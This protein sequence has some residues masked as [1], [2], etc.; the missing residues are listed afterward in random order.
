MTS[1]VSFGR[2]VRHRRKAL[3]LTQKDLAQRVGCSV[4]AIRKLEADERRPSQ[5][6]A[7]RLAEFLIIP[8]D[9]RAAF[10]QA[11]RGERCVDRLSF[12]PPTV[13][14]MLG[15]ISSQRVYNLPVPLTPLLGRQHELVQI[16]RL[17]QDPQCRLLTLTG[18]GGIGK[19]RLAIEVAYAQHSSFSD[20]VYFV[21][22][23]HVTAIE[24][25]APTIADILGF[26]FHGPSD[27]HKQLF[28]YLHEKS[29]LLV[30]DNFEHLLV[31]GQLL[32]DLLQN[33]PG[34][35]VLVTS[36]GRLNVHGEWVFEVQGLPVPPLDQH[37]EL[38]TY[39]A[40]ALF[41]QSARRV[42]P[43]FSLAECNQADVARICQL[44]D[45][46]PLG[47]ELAATWIRVL[48]CSEIAHEIEHNVDFLAVSA[49][50]IPERHRS[51]RAA[52]DHSWNLLSAE[53][54]RVMRQLAVF[55]GGFRREAAGQVA[56][57]S[58]PLLSALVDKSLL[59]RTGVGRYGMHQLVEQYVLAH[60]EADPGECAATHDRYS[61]YYA[62]MLQ[63]HEE[64]LKA[65]IRTD[66]VA[67]LTLEIDNLRSAW[68][69][70]VAHQKIVDIRQAVRS[71]FW[72]YESR[73]WLREGESVFR[74][75]AD[76]LR[77]AI[78]PN[79]EGAAEY[80]IALG[81]ALTYQAVFHYRCGQYGWAKEL[82]EQSLE[83]L[84]QGN[85]QLAL[86]EAL[87]HL[88]YV[89]YGAGAYVQA[90]QAIDESLSISVAIR[91]EWGVAVCLT[92]L[93]SITH[94]RGEYQE[95]SDWFRQGLMVWRKVGAARGTAYCLVL[96]GSTSCALGQYDQAQGLLRES[97]SISRALDDRWGIA[98]TLN[99]LGM[100]FHM[101]GDYVEAQS[102]FRESLT[103]F[104]ELGDRL[105]IAQTLNWLGEV[106]RALGTQPEAWTSFLE[107]IN[108]ATRM[109]T[110][111]VVLEALVGLASLSAQEGSPEWA[112]ELLESVL[113]HPAANK[114][115]RDRA[116]QLHTRLAVQ[117][118]P[119][120]LE[121]IHARAQ[122]K[123]FD[124]FLE[125][126]LCEGADR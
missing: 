62:T 74:Q 46:M 36:R 71:L 11:A 33:A 50:G 83:L 79:G 7:E 114:E 99:A 73:G 24:Y 112:L 17:L 23:A 108:I 123:P 84:R 16:N 121:A 54:Q 118:P 44:L 38:E 10:V 42:A 106:H 12:P 32:S 49:R 4:S 37:D 109:D 15:P 64:A 97:L 75:A 20:G 61:T 19:T 85:D 55:R 94:A 96:F 26:T 48:S 88:A 13:D 100:L 98:S 82:L 45:G 41:L 9:D 89:H 107:A 34:A 5:Q 6:M 25:V 18:L 90:H 2:W 115:V 70:A 1:E 116:Q 51:L 43:G 35:R 30:L 102:L 40:V 120:Q 91:H 101:R 126:V 105:G 68:E 56:G 52:F 104:K 8:L 21:P 14:S 72:L 69:W 122:T 29:L 113:A 119:A 47:I 80:A 57:A 22:L 78:K 95:A 76:T 87:L 58:L 53:E 60:L 66:T 59:R 103:L 86:S 28:D 67:E 117:L 110:L 65:G 124:T 63:R 111:P 77:E 27:V 92:L 81:Q 125:E 31:A 39:S 3:D 93:G